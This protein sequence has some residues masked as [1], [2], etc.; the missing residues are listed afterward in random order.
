VSIDQRTPTIVSRP[1]LSDSLLCISPAS[2]HR[3]LA[4]RY[5]IR[6]AKALPWSTQDHFSLAENVFCLPLARGQPLNSRLKLKRQAVALHR[7]SACT[8]LLYS[9]KLRQ[10]EHWIFQHPGNIS[11]PTRLIPENFCWGARLLQIR[12]FWVWDSFLRSALKFFCRDVLGSRLLT[13]LGYF[14]YSA[15][16]HARYRREAIGVCPC[17]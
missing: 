16:F 1:L 14:D 13:T 6:C 4:R 12:I 7:R 15:V 2:S 10:K 17:R 11:G 3:T 5:S 8:L 9:E